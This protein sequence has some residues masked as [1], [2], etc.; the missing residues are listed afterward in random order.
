MRPGRP[1]NGPIHATPAPKTAVGGVDDGIHRELSNITVDDLYHDPTHSA[2]FVYTPGTMETLLI[3]ILLGFAVWFWTDSLRARE[4]AIQLSQ[5]ACRQHGVQL[6]DATVS[7][8]RIGLK[9]DRDG[10]LR[11]HRCYRFDFSD[12]DQS[13]QQ[14]HI[15]LLG[16]RLQ[17][18]AMEP[19]PPLE[20]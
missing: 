18:M 4:A 6:L 5:M 10:Q 17:S 7:L 9:R 8:W 13:R 12:E 19:H 20:H 11:I 14:G 1:M 15:Q 3:L 16:R 2:G